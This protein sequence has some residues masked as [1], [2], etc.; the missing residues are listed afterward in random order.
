M[1]HLLFIIVSLGLCSSILSAQF[2]LDFDDPTIPVANGEI[3]NTQY[4]AKYGVEVDSVW[5]L[6][7]TTSRN[8]P[9]VIFDSTD[10]PGDPTDDNVPTGGDTD[11]ET[12]NPVGHASNTTPL[13]NVL[14][15]SEDNFSG[16]GDNDYLSLPGGGY[17]AKN[18]DDNAGGG[19]LKFTF[20][21]P[22]TLSFLEILD[23]EE[24][25]GSFVGIQTGGNQLVQSLAAPGD[26]SYQK[27]DFTDWDS[28]EVLYV[29]FVGSGAVASL[30]YT[31][32]PE[33]GTIAL[34]GI[35]L[36]AGYLGLRKRLTLRRK[37]A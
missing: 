14:I 15:V 4:I 35:A 10:T 18:P 9:A 16:P 37:K 3:I 7:N 13:E 8:K 27:V 20:F 28:I 22:A 6:T 25:G 19:T 24:V 29:D 11:L 33:P 31:P 32:I 30:S 1:K 34:G 23:I 12:P 17:A 36:L 2:I 26:S 21:T 5:S